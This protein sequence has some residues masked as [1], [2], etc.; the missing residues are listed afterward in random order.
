M[1]RVRQSLNRLSYLYYKAKESD[2]AL[3]TESQNAVETLEKVVKAIHELQKKPPGDA[4]SFFNLAGYHGEPFQ[5][6]GTTDPKWWGGYC[7]HANVLFPTWHRM[8]LLR[9]EDAMRTVPGCEDVALPF[10]DECELDQNKKPMP[11]PE[12]LTRE[13]F[14]L[15]NQDIPNPLFSYKL[16]KELKHEVDGAAHRYSKPL[17]YQTVRYPRSGLVGNA[18]DRLA[19]RSQNSDFAHHD[20]CTIL[21]N[22]NVSSWLQGNIK[23]TRDGIKET[24][25]ADTTSVLGRYNYCLDASTYTIFSNVTS[26]KNA[27]IKTHPPPTSLESPHNA[28]HLAVG[29]FYQPG[30]YNANEIAGANGD[31]GD[32]ETASF[33]PIFFFHHCF[34]DYV[35]WLWQRRH[36]STTNLVIDPNDRGAVLQ[37]GVGSMPPKTKLNMDTDLQPFKKPDQ[38]YWKSKDL[39]NI[40]KIEGDRGYKYGPGSLDHLASPHKPV[41]SPIR[42]PEKG[43]DKVK[44]VKK[45]TVNRAVHRGSFVIRM[46]AQPPGKMELI[47]IGREPVLSRWD[48]EDCDNCRDKLDV[49]LLVPL[50]GGMLDYLG[51]D[52]KDGEY[53]EKITYLGAVQSYGQMDFTANLQDMVHNA[54]AENLQDIHPSAVKLVQDVDLPL[55]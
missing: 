12:V 2:E 45:I 55:R 27:P 15:G 42:G 3:N 52:N 40:E 23:I 6:Q 47:E 54:A 1:T 43:D 35:F 20:W 25:I 37:E 38:T 32:N 13:K 41:A 9:Y 51:E 44:K 50:T 14:R 34:V 53:G 16:Q 33:D 29:G 39:V 26:Q 28:M 31:M 18:W 30:V 17:D 8:Y 19:T 21:L 7:H 48:V 49:D 22:R 5:G 46:F 36:G 11:I 4:N 24:K 10:W